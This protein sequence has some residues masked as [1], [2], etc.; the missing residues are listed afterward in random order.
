ME[1]RDTAR[2]LRISPT[3]VIEELKKDRYLEPVNRPLLEQM[4]N[5]TEPVMVVR[6]EEAE[7]DEM[8]RF[9]RS[10]KI[11][12]WM[13]SLRAPM[14][15]VKQGTRFQNTIGKMQQLSHYGSNHLFFSLAFGK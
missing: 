10:K 3:T 2:V 8:W 15:G 9:V 11:L 6:V 7:I 12:C 4:E 14:V 5:C 1:I 13:S